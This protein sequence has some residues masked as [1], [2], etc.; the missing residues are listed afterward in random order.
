MRYAFVARERARYPL[1]L[2][3]RVL[4]ASVS[5][6][7]DWLHRQG[8]PDPEAA[9]RVE[10][11]SLH[12]DSRGT[13]GRPRLVQALRARAHRMGHKRVARL[14]RQE[15]LR[16]KVKGRSKL[17]TTDSR[18]G[19][20]VVG[21]HL[22]RRFAVDHPLPVWVGDITYLP[23][24]E[25]WLYLAAVIDLRTR[26]V[27]GYSLSERM[28]DDLVRQAFINAWSASPVPPDAI[29]HSDRGSQ[30]ASGAFT[31]TLAAHGFVPSMSRKGNCWE[32]AACPQGTTPWPRASS[33]RSR[34]RKPPAYTPPRLQPTLPSPA[35][36][37]AST[38]LSVSTP[39]L[40]ICRP[41]TMP[42][43]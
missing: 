22:D 24:R 13:Y 3:C 11:R 33:P 7:H 32:R 10:L 23:T 18:H 4:S 38:I 31:K 20:S 37:M 25:G 28:P 21:N 40:V 8:R 12:T 34:T 1:R 2:L 26:Q 42:R 41:T 9:L 39:R 30:Y 17:R 27:L 19:R 43:R 16:G 5:G 36:S 6:Y 15:G 29:F 14:M 35:T